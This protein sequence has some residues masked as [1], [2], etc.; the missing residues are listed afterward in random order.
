MRT[1]FVCLCAAIMSTTADA[2]PEADKNSSAAIIGL[3]WD[4]VEAPMMV[5]IW[6][7]IA[8]VAKILFHVNKKFGDAFPD[9]ALLIAVG[10][11]LGWLLD[12]WNVQSSLFTLNATTFFL[13]LLPPIIFDAGY[14]MPNRQLFENLG[15]VLTFAVVGTI[16]NFVAIGG[17]LIVCSHYKLFTVD[18]SWAE[19]L[20][21][22]SLISA[23]D[24]VAVI[25][26]FE[27]IG[28]NEFLFINTFGEALFNDG[29][30]AAIFQVFDRIVTTGAENLHTRQYVEYSGALV[31]IALGGVCVGVLMAFVCSLATRFTQRVKIVG[32][33]FIFVFPYASYLIAEMCGLSAI[34]AICSCGIVMK[35]YV[36]GNITHEAAS[37]VKYSVKMLAQASETVVFM[38][39][40]LSAMSSHQ[41]F[42]L[43]FVIVTL[44]SCT[45]FRTIGVIVQCAI[46]NRYSSK[47]F[48]MRDQFILAYGGLRGA[49]AFGLLSSVPDSVAAKNMFATTT[50]IVI[51]F[52]VFLQGSTIRP[53]LSLLKVE[54]AEHR[55]STMIENVYNKYFD[56]TMAGIEDVVGQKGKHAVRDWFER[57]NAKV[58][59]PLLVKHTARNVF[60]ASHIVRAY[61]KI[62]LQEAIEMARIGERQPSTSLNITSLE[63]ASK[64]RPTFD[65]FMASTENVNRLYAMMRELLVEMQQNEAA[66]T[67]AAPSTSQR[68]HTPAPT[69]RLD[70]DEFDDIKDDYI[71]AIKRPSPKTFQRDRQGSKSIGARPEPSN[72]RLTR[73]QSQPA[74]PQNANISFV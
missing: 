15:S 29:I 66:G 1:V 25:T 9:S 44:T 48:T 54:K 39:L 49:I 37:S 4:H 63:G 72:N 3:H 14:F 21:F 38:F 10:L 51:C 68:R 71:A 31:A 34:L 13:Y 22:S 61:N 23:V 73:P 57:L 50:I 47:K 56:F 26:V 69:A 40:G 17:T 28:V 30:A 65:E 36:K 59:K 55:Q 42:D 45:V 58:L 2:S 33:V 32:P 20:L 7:L 12:A 70:G 74:I 46:L 35:Q 52:T 16:W 67:A 43:W 62:A 5:S 8:S 6:L 24:P 53:L 64:Q 41:Y 19:A 18:F 27:E 60:D 11:L